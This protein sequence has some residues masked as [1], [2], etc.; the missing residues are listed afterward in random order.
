MR[1]R[2]MACSDDQMLALGCTMT[3]R[4]AVAAVPN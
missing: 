2:L 4:V 1:A 3:V